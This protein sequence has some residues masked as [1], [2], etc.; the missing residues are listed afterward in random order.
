MPKRKKSAA[1][2]DVP[3]VT[4]PQAEPSFPTVGIGAS[5][6]GVSALQTFLNEIPPTTGAAYVIIVH[7]EPTHAS[8]LAE[9]LARKAHMP[10]R[11]VNKKMTLEPDNIYVIPPNRRLLITDHEI[12]TFVFDEP[13]GRRSPIDQ[14]F[15]SLADQHG[16]GFA[17]VLT[18][19]GSDGAVGA[20]AIKEAGGLILVQDPNEAEYPSMPR[21]A[22]ATGLADVVLPVRELGRQLVELIKAKAHVPAEQLP[23]S[24]EETLKQVLTFLRSR[25]GHDFLRYKRSTIYR[26]LARRMQVRKV[27]TLADYFALIKRKPEEVTSLF[28]DLL[29]SVTTFF[30]DPGSFDAL[31]QKVVPKLYDFDESSGPIRVWIPGCA[32]GEE[33]YSIAMLFADEAARRD[34]RAE[35]QLFASDLD[36]TAL[37]IAREGRYPL[38]IEADVG[39]ERLRKY[40]TKDADHYR[41]RREI[42]DMVLFATHSLLKDPPFSKLHLIS[43]RNLLIYLEKDLQQQ[44][45]STFNYALRPGGYLFLG[46]SETAEYPPGLFRVLDREARI[47]Q[48]RGPGA[49]HR[50][51]PHLPIPARVGEIPVLNAPA[52]S[53]VPSPPASHQHALELTAPPSM[54]VDKNHQIVNMSE[55]VGRFVQPSGGQMRNDITELVRPELRFDLRAALHMA[56]ERGQPSLSL[57]IP[58]RFNGVPHRVF[59]QVRPVSSEQVSPQQAVVFFI[60]GDAITEAETEAAPSVRDQAADGV[61]RGLKEELELTRARLRAS[62]E[63]YEAANEELRAAN[64]ELQSINEEYRSTAE[65]LETSK[66]ELQSMNEELQTVNAELKIKLDGVSRTNNDLQNLMAATDVGTLFLDSQLHIKRFTP[67][68]TEL[69]NLK[70]P[71]EGRSIT[72]FTHRL[73]YP[74]FTEDAQ[75]V[76]KDLKIIE[77]EIASNGNWYLTRLRPYRTLDDRIEGVVCTFVD[78]TERVKTRET[79]AANEARLRLLLSE[80]SHRVKNT[81]AVVQSIARQTFNQALPEDDALEIFSNRLRALAE[82][83][84]LLIRSDWH[85]ADFQELAERQIAPYAQ[86]DGRRVILSG[87]PVNM[88]PDVA[89]PLALMLHELATNA[90]KYG[91]L[92]SPDG[93]LRV[94]WGF[95]VNG[96]AREFRYNWRESGG[97]KI[98]RPMREGFGSWLIQN[99]LPDAKVELT[100]PA[101]GAL[102]AVTIPAEHLGDG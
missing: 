31:A 43:C 26:R 97:P 77:R 66:E 60:E 5:A 89:T 12:A 3:D 73:D 64:E 102:C 69:F 18:G 10:V 62:R 92:S 74:N 24:D 39:E 38:A 51:F 45:L 35:L 80:L 8:E 85:G 57:G 58:V 98:E 68:I 48:S 52:H 88:P 93:T 21:S 96:G 79:L 49:E 72:D 84:N 50:D 78:M 83:H 2:S 90:T 40:F 47:Y 59:L 71:D 1:A 54:L 37:S 94:D 46:S 7:L 4:P 17:V 65:E 19:A 29:I 16:D 36:T 34:S 22:I 9:I 28:H 11:Q 95:R 41:I 27:E 61:I 100:F 86:V 6:G 20:K 33:A 76:L 23:P 44:V 87:P 56:F 30:R 75:I 91:A 25:T 63:E 42:R 82:A 67:R 99:G 13:R 55:G 53:T 70:G 15:R 81:L 14:F 32:S 101:T